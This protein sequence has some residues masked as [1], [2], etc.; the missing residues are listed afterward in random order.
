M[1][2]MLLSMSIIDLSIIQ[3]RVIKHL[4]CTVC[5]ER[6]DTILIQGTG[7]FYR[8]ENCLLWAG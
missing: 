3:R 8:I 5:A 6:Y 1:M 7:I 2:S 4:Y